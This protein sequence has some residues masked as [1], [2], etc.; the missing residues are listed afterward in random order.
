MPKLSAEIA[1][2]QKLIND[3]SEMVKRITDKPNT[4]GAAVAHRLLDAGCDDKAVL[5]SAALGDL[6][7]SVHTLHSEVTPKFGKRSANAWHDLCMAR[8]H[9]HREDCVLSCDCEVTKKDCTHAHNANCDLDPCVLK[10]LNAKAPGTPG[11]S[12]AA[13]MAWFD[14][15]TER[16]AGQEAPGDWSRKDKAAYLA[17]LASVA[18][19]I[20]EKGNDSIHTGIIDR[21]AKN[22]Q[23]TVKKF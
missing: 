16:M 14:F 21:L 12:R 19:H 13:L 23:R 3:C 20:E 15:L 4:N 2:A 5:V 6:P 7:Y 1:A 22:V 11:A 8:V 9:A 10:R 17:K 18:A